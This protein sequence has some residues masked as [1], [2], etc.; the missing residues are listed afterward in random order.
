MHPH[1]QLSPSD[2]HCFNC[3]A[4]GQSMQECERP[5]KAVPKLPSGATTSPEVP[6]SS[7]PAASKQVATPKRGRKMEAA[8]EAAASGASATQATATFQNASEENIERMFK[9]VACPVDGPHIVATLKGI[10]VGKTRG[11]L[12]GGATHSLCYATPGE[13]RLARPVQVHLASG[14]TYHLRMNTGTLLSQDP[15]VQ[16]IVSMGLLAEVTCV[17]R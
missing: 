11:L 6:S 13:Y 7:H 9:S 16:P 3:G 1:E 8:S 2:H 5:S 10:D 12:D 4:A 17:C 14:S 15:E